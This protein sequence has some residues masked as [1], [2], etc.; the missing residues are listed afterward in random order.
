MALGQFTQFIAQFEILLLGFLGLSKNTR[1]EGD[2][3]E[4]EGD[5]DG[6]N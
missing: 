4:G 6:E 2:E 3:G 1:D 5:D